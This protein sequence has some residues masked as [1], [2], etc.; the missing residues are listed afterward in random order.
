MIYIFL[1]AKDAGEMAK[2]AAKVAMVFTT[3][4]TDVVVKVSGVEHLNEVV[5]MVGNLSS[6]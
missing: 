2:V 3:E 6:T 4:V 5:E 1:E